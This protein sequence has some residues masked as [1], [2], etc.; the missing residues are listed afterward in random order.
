MGRRKSDGDAFE[1]G[2]SRRPELILTRTSAQLDKLIK[3]IEAEKDI[4]K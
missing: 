1:E 4:S 2:G 3:V